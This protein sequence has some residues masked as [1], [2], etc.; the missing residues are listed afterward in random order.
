MAVRG[1]NTPQKAIPL[2]PILEGESNEALAK[3]ARALLAFTEEQSLAVQESF[4]GTLRTLSYSTNITG[5]Y[6]V[7]GEFSHETVIC[8]N[9]SAVTVT[10]PARTEGARVTVVRASTGAVTIDGNGTNIA[11]TSTRTLSTQYT[12]DALIASNLEWVLT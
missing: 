7:T 8:N 2:T 6:S 4:E 12:A 1:R 5:N 10:L 11:G 9:T 3:W